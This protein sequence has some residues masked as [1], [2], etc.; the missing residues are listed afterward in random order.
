MIRIRLRVR[1]SGVRVRGIVDAYVKGVFVFRTIQPQAIESEDRGIF[2]LFVRI[3]ANFLSE[4][5]YHLNVTIHAEQ[6][7][8]L[9][10]F[11]PNAISFLAYGS[12][13]ADLYRNAL[14]APRFA[15][16]VRKYLHELGSTEYKRRKAAARQ[17]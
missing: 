6:E 1:K 12:E 2:D 16:S 8:E 5:T 3:P 4:T 13:D 11:L 7:K 17:R 14:L 10:A 15:W 9:K